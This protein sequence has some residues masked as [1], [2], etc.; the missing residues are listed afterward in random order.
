MCLDEMASADKIRDGIRWDRI[1]L[2]SLG[3]DMDG[4][5]W[6]QMGIWKS[7]MGWDCLG[8]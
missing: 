8:K 7:S 1:G 3:W 6:E 5:G 4:M 2:P